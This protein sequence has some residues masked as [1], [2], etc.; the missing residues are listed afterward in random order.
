MAIYHLNAKVHSR[1]TDPKLHALRSYAYRSGTRIVDPIT[2][3]IYNYQ[4][5]QAEPNKPRSS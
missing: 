5:K 3:R 1:G 4:S 2:G